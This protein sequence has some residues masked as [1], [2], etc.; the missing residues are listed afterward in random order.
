M[1]A[2]RTGIS[3]S[4]FSHLSQEGREQ[5][6]GRLQKAFNELAT[7]YPMARQNPYW[8][9][10]IFKRLDWE[11]WAFHNG[12]WDDFSFPAVEECFES[13]VKELPTV[14]RIALLDPRL[15]IEVVPLEDDE[16]AAPVEDPGAPT[17]A[18]PVHRQKWIKEFV[19][20]RPATRVLLLLFQ[21][22]IKRL[23]KE[24]VIE[25]LRHELGHAL[26]YL[27]KPKAK[28]D[29]AAADEE[30]KRC[31][32]LEDLIVQIPIELS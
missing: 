11:N 10:F 9:T 13:V 25:D 20:V 30:W 24:E 32:Q 26:L 22:D 8:K 12:W 2:K 29:C 5:V 21:R 16:P 3:N 6:F 14:S 4:H 17:W 28:N 7:Y 23:P 18:F 27:R 19:E 15:Q 31:T 1:N